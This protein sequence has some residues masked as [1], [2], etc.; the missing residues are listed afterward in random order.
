VSD[1]QI[2]GSKLWAFSNRDATSG[3]TLASQKTLGTG[4]L[5]L[6][7]NH[8]TRTC[9]REGETDLTTIRGTLSPDTR[10]WAQFLR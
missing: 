9:A 5:V 1:S 2:A 6:R 7:L 10:I 3:M 4:V 8:S